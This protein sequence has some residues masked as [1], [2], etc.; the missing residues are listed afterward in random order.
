MQKLVNRSAASK[1]RSE[2]VHGTIE[3][4]RAV[5]GTFVY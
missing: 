2:R 4:D 3:L 5:F 1:T